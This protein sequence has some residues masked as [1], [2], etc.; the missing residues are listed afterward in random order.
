MYSQLLP[1]EKACRIVGGQAAL[2]KILGI[3]RMVVHQWVK[4]YSPLPIKR[5]VAIEQATEG[6]IT[7][8]DLRPDDWH[9]IWPELNQKGE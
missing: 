5:C 6:I 7:R 8:R 1:L 2:A 9:L 4:G 3:S